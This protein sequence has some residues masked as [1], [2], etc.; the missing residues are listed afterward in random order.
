MLTDFFKV[1]EVV[2]GRLG[3]KHPSHPHA[4]P[5]AKGLAFDPVVMISLKMH[6]PGSNC[7]S[8]EK[9]TNDI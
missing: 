5:F 9:K 7:P 6:T 2:R 3:T 4:L 8:T 1:T